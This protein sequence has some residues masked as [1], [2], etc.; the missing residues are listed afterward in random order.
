MLRRWKI[1]LLKLD[2]INAAK[3]DTRIAVE[4]TET[5]LKGLASAINSML[6]PY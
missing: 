1:S 5:E 2:S 4:E 6:G 3:L